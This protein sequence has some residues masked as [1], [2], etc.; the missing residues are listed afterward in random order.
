MLLHKAFCFSLISI[1]FGFELVIGPQ[2]IWPY[3]Q[4]NANGYKS[5]SFQYQPKAF[6][7]GNVW[8][9]QVPITSTNPLAGGGV[10]ISSLGMW[11]AAGSGNITTR[12]GVYDEILP[13]GYPSG[14]LTETGSFQTVVGSNQIA[15]LTPVNVTVPP[16]GAVH[17]WLCALFG[18]QC[19]VYAAQTTST[20]TDGCSKPW[21]Q[22]GLPSVF[23]TSAPNGTSTAMNFWLRGLSLVTVTIT[24]TA[25]LS[26]TSTATPTPTP[27]PTLTS[28]H[29]LTP[30]STPTMTTTDTIPP[31]YSPGH[32]QYLGIPLPP[33]LLTRQWID[34]TPSHVV[35][36]ETFEL[37]VTGWYTFTGTPVWLMVGRG[38]P[39]LDCGSAA[40]GSTPQLLTKGRVTFTV[41][42]NDTYRICVKVR[43]DWERINRTLVVAPSAS[44]GLFFGYST[45][46]GVV[47]WNRTICGCWYGSAGP[48]VTVPSSFAVRLLDSA[49]SPANVVNSLCCASLGYRRL[50]GGTSLA[51]VP[52]GFCM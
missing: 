17:V 4:P 46:D 14:L 9:T 16:G 6:S 19:S 15:V 2:G 12:L 5:G 13:A 28:T 44:A 25:T 1:T 11:V 39:Y 33:E 8:C 34:Y 40:P 43:D 22:A 18:A 32:Y 37:L 47:A 41:S 27:T 51:G 30:T 20:P 29:T 21:S 31:T 24:P 7:A 10:E 49:G 42:G 45:C 35:A 36:G 26:P 50:S 3:G 52:W 48:S 23:A 38:G